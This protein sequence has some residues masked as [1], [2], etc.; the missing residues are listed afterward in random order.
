MH[1]LCSDFIDQTL[2]LHFIERFDALYNDQ[3]RIL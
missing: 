3:A 1:I 2:I